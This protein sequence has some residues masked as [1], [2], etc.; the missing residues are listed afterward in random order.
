MDIIRPS[1]KVIAYEGKIFLNILS[2]YQSL[3]EF[4]K[5]F[6]VTSSTQ[7]MPIKFIAPDWLRDEDIDLFTKDPGC[8]SEFSYDYTEDSLE[9]SSAAIWFDSMYVIL[10]IYNDLLERRRKPS[11]INSLL[12]L[13]TA[14]EFDITTDERE[15]QILPLHKIVTD[16]KL[17]NIIKEKVFIKV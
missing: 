3:L 2:S 11:E 10:K 7:V 16:T 17:I 14:V 13:C 5:F 8:T 6:K 12:P 15:L 1:V 4:S 9:I